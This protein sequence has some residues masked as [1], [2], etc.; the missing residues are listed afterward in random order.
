MHIALF[1]IVTLN[2]FRVE[3]YPSETP[4]SNRVFYNM[5]TD[6]DFFKQDRADFL[7][8]FILQ[9]ISATPCNLQLPWLAAS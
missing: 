8:V 2:M 9:Q 4:R 5:R 6:A 7:S 3:Q 1:M